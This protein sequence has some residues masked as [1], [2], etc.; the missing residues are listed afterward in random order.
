MSVRYSEIRDTLKTGDLVSWKA[1]KV[2]SFFTAIL[3]IYQ[4]ILK[5]KS[6]HVGI[7][8]VVGGRT[9]IVEARPPVVRIY[10]LSRMEDFYLIRTN[11]P[12]D[13]ANV[14]FLLQEVGVEYGILDLIRGLLFADGKNNKELYCSELASIYYEHIGTLDVNKFPEA[15]RTP[16]N[17][18]EAVCDATGSS[19]IYVEIDKG[20]LNAV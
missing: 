20:N 15:W 9:F 18:I 1:G 5:P 12:D 19:P 3:K 11:I 13:K 16:D 10:P 8:F 6:V 2:D 7:V 4:K 17:L 14:D